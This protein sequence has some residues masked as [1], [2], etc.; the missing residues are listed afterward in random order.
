MWIKVTRSIHITH[1]YTL[2]H[3]NKCTTTTFKNF[4]VISKLKHVCCKTSKA[5]FYNM[6]TKLNH[7]NPASRTLLVCQQL[8]Y[9]WWRL[10]HCSLL[11][12][13]KPWFNKKCV[14]HSHLAFTKSASITAMRF[15]KWRHGGFG[16]DN[17]VHSKNN[18]VQSNFVVES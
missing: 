6:H 1:L 14:N 2:H 11:R 18:K 15:L 5:H 4:I 3:N 8:R 9:T 12:T 7:A 17:Y 10:F 16:G 13:R